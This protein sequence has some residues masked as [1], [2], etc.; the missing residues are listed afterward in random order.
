MHFLR[1]IVAAQ[2]AGIPR[3]I[4]SICSAN[5]FVIE[6]ALAR[7]LHSGSPVLI[8]ATC[9]QVN[10]F[11]G[12]MGMRPAEFRAYV[13]RIA[14]R[15]GL[16]AERI[17]LGGDHLGPN[18]WRR[19]PAAAAMGK[20]A[21]LVREYVQAG[22]TKIH[23]DASMPLGDDPG[24][25]TGIEPRTAAARGAEL[26]RAA[27]EAARPLATKPVYVIGTEVPA[28]GGSREAESGVAV[29]KPAHFEETVE[30]AR[31]MFASQG[32][33][34]AWE[35]VIAVVVQPGV[36]FGGET[37]QEYQRERCRDLIAAGRKRPELV[38][39]G[40]STDYQRA[41]VLKEMVEDGIAVLKVGP[42]LTF[43]LR[44]AVFALAD[45]E[46]ELWSRREPDRLSRLKE[47]LD[48]AMLA[49]PDD[50]RPYYPGDEA[51]AALARKYS[52]F[53]RCRY[54]WS[55][56]EVQAA[57]GRL[58]SNLEERQPPLSL[59]SQYLP[60]Q[61]RKIREGRLHN[62]PRLLIRDR[63]DEVLADYAYATMT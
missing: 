52:L 15:V 30:L 2:A 54:Y 61:Y 53:D 32:L 42:G 14:A 17:I 50:W 63:I 49:A 34:A 25:E 8:E 31:R 51:T 41:G 13:H 55:K 16:P 38:F 29:T 10:Q 6:A 62:T 45:M 9:N 56:P 7:A 48:R 24:G 46:Y 21:A 36:E 22:F 33:E 18:P 3:G 39:E 60:V 1:E 37:V 35:R 4:P 26:C 28:P 11:G 19:E 5:E 43:A 44:E 59:V 47:T 23:L 58:L 12:Y 40:H 27:E 20:A 57:L